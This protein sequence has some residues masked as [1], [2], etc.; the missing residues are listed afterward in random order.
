M[1]ANASYLSRRRRENQGGAF[2][3]AELLVVIAIIGILAA[4]LL[5]ALNMAKRS[6]WKATCLN[7]LK[8]INLGVRMY[9]DDSGG[10]MPEFKG[11]GGYPNGPR[12]FYK[13]L[14]K[15]YVGLHGPSGPNDL[16]FACPADRT[17]GSVRPL[18]LMPQSDYT[19]YMYNNGFNFFK[20]GQSGLMAGKFDSV[21]VPAN[22]ILVAEQPAFLGY[23]W[24]NPQSGGVLVQPNTSGPLTHGAGELYSYNNAQAMVSFVDGHVKY[25]KIYYDGKRAPFNYNPIPGYEYQWTGDVA[26][27]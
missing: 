14:V 27:K 4:I 24:H 12:F 3:L 10:R 18:S 5:P 16:I 20:R 26:T 7:N 8:Q 23:S 22:T 15:S 21:G 2:T 9:T 11:W 6:A 13:E 1:S 25:I 17:S 19:S